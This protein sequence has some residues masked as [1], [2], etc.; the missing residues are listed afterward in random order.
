M[1]NNENI[2]VDFDYQNIIVVD[3]NKVV[4]ENGNVKERYIKQENLVMYANLECT[5]PPRTKL[6]VGNSAQDAVQTLSIASINF[7][8]PQ[9]GDKLTNAYTDEITGKGSLER[10]ENGNFLGIN[11]NV[12]TSIRRADKPN[13]FYNLKQQSTE[14]ALG[15]VDTG[16]LGMTSI[17]I[18]YN[19]DFL[20]VINVTLEDVKGRALFESGNNSPYRAFF[21]YP[22]P[23]F[24]L[25]LK[26][27]YGKA[28]KYPLM[29]QDFKAKVDSESGNFTIDLKFFTYRYSMLS[30]ISMQSMQTVPHMYRTTI[31]VDTNKNP[32]IKT[33]EVTKVELTKGYQKVLEVY[34]DYKSKGLI[35]ENFPPLTIVQLQRKLDNFIQ[36][37]LNNFP[38]Q[39]LTAYTSAQT[40]RDLLNS[41][42]KEITETTNPDSWFVKYIDQKNYFILNN[43]LK[44]YELLG[45]NIISGGVTPRNI[46]ETIVNSELESICVKYSKS[47]GKENMNN[48]PDFGAN[49]KDDKYR[50]SEFKLKLSDFQI[51][52]SEGDLDYEK[53]YIQQTG[54]QPIDSGGTETSGF[55]FYKAQTQLYFQQVSNNQ[56]YNI[57]ENQFT[58]APKILYYFDGKIGI[59]KKS[60]IRKVE[61]QSKELELQFEKYKADQLIKL[62]ETSD[63]GIGFAP[64]LRNVLAV[65]Y[66][67]GE[68]Y[69]RLIDDVHRNSWDQRSNP[70]RFNA[71]NSAI[72]GGDQ[73]LDSTT[74]E[75]KFVYPWPEICVLTTDEKESR[76]DVR[77]P[78][79]KDLAEQFQAYDFSVWPE[80]EFVE[81]YISGTVLRNS[82]PSTPSIFENNLTQSQYTS[83][84]ALE[85]PIDN[86][87]Y[88]NKEQ[89][90][91]LYEIWER[92]YVI[93]NY[94]N[95]NRGGSNFKQVYDTIATIESNNILKSLGDTNPFLIKALKEYGLNSRNF[96][97]V[98]R[99]I[100]NEGQGE[101]WQTHIRGYYNTPYI[102]NI[103]TN[104]F[105]LKPFNSGDTNRI[106]TDFPN[107]E[108]FSGYVVDSSTNILTD[109]DIYP[110]T[111]KNWCKMNLANGKFINDVNT[112]NSTSKV[113]QVNQSSK[114]ICNFLNDDSEFQ[115]RPISNFNYKTVNQPLLSLITPY[116][117]ENIKNLYNIR[118]TSFSQ[119]HPTEGNLRY[120][121]YTGPTTATQTTSILNT[122]YFIN[123]IQDGLV[124][125]RNSEAYPYVSGAYLFLNSLPL[126]TLRERYKSLEVAQDGTSNPTDLDYI[127]A[128]LKKFNAVHKIPYA[129]I[130]RYGSIWHRYKEYIKNG[131]D[132]LSPIWTN[133]DRNFNYDP[134]NSSPQKLY[135]LTINGIQKKIRLQADTIVGNQTLTDINV[136]F[137]PKLIN[138][139]SSFFKGTPLFDDYSDATIQSKIDNEFFITDGFPNANLT[140][141]NGVDENNPNRSI[142]ISSWSSFLKVNSTLGFVLPSVGLNSNQF[143][144]ENFSYTDP[145]QPRMVNEVNN[146]STLYDGSVRLAWASPNYGYFDNSKLLIPPPTKY[147]KKIFT[148]FSAKQENFSISGDDDYSDISELFSVFNKDILDSF[149]RE[150]LNF[151]K[152]IFDTNI[153]SLVEDTAT[154]VDQAVFSNFQYLIRNILKVTPTNGINTPTELS[155]LGNNVLNNMYQVIGKFLSYDYYLKFGNPNNFNQRIFKSF[156][157]LGSNLTDPF[158]YN[159]YTTNSPNALPSFNNQFPIQQ[160]QTTYPTAWEALQEYVGFSEFTGLKYASSGSAIFDFFIDNN[161][162]FGEDTIKNLYPLIKI[163]A[164]Q[165]LKD[166]SYNA[167]KF[168]GTL[169][170]II[171][172]NSDFQDKI[173]NSLMQKLTKELPNVNETP[174]RNIPSE[175]KGDV[176][177]IALWQ[178]FKGLN[179]RWIAGT[180]VSYKTLFED[181]LFLDRAGRDIGSEIYIDVFSLNQRIRDLD[182]KVSLL[183]FSNEL[184]KT[185]NFVVF[186]YPSY[187]NFYGVQS[188]IKNST[189][190][191]DSSYDFANNLFGTHMNVDLVESS[192][193]MVCLYGGKPST[194]LDGGDIVSN[195]KND[196]FNL[197]RVNQNPCIQDLTNKTD[198]DKSNRLVG[199]TVDFG[200]INQG[201]FTKISVGQDN[202]KP[203]KETLDA[204][205]RLAS[206]GEGRGGSSQYLS[207]YDI[208]SSRSYKCDITMMG[209]VLIQPTMYFNL[210]HIPLFNGPYMITSVN[211]SINP[212]SFTTKFDGIRQSVYSYPKV[213]DPLETIRKSFIDYFK[214]SFKQQSTQE[215]QS[216]DNNATEA[217]ASKV[218]NTVSKSENAKSPTCSASTAFSDFSL[219]SSPQKTKVTAS[220]V[221][222]F[223]KTKYGTS[224]NLIYVIMTI[225][226][227]ETAV[228]PE[229]TYFESYENNYAGLKLNLKDSAGNDVTF[230][231]K[232]SLKQNYICMTTATT[233]PEQYPLATFF[234]FE[235]CVDFI[236]TRMS[237]RLIKLQ[238]L[239]NI[240]STDNTNLNDNSEKLSKFVYDFWPVIN[241]GSYEKSTNKNVYKELTKKMI[242]LVNSNI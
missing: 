26:G 185:N 101:S 89:V 222:N 132:I 190:K 119:Q 155:D 124:K 118:S 83:V 136:G 52:V 104:T 166:S 122:P 22:Y 29:L 197:K 200:T 109:Y 213:T 202:G 23:I 49:S 6:S 67:N 93:S 123:S 218:N 137:Y 98:L 168:T 28:V 134:I 163:Y 221:I 108:S 131:S 78:G 167:S 20:P 147:M 17:N 214:T 99:H 239:N 90:K 195:F 170:D 48:V 211:H 241:E 217:D 233:P 76:Y 57:R 82:V 173:F 86:Q 65:F 135:T 75:E 50:T 64:T 96:E 126:A 94:T 201:V 54:L 186:T 171:N 38:K 187:I 12:E 39:D 60:F 149:E 224:N 138:D 129:W 207:M 128:T 225:M 41:I 61:E 178:T 231:N 242:E 15:S 106:L 8:K 227:Q 84:N 133:F 58:P 220:E 27:Y 144:I 192:P 55:T 154:T 85:F 175:L 179:D 100:S 117:S 188:P 158:V 172:N 219:I 120:K 182:P 130:L 164:T 95:L 216:V 36:N 234:N 174:T 205:S 10:D 68:A 69:L 53:T 162:E 19:L 107:I 102:R 5:V 43:G 236:A 30:E 34:N 139:F 204:L 112:I 121:N 229:Y 7:L 150:F 42:I 151:S 32:I 127:Y 74:G 193:K 88:F 56:I 110:F 4:D 24:Y 16:L 142:Y 145:I 59:L 198:W 113:I 180:N 71:I 114:I 1:V 72:Q 177:K 51:E 33:N 21:S 111:D 165:K 181:I 14:G 161:V 156:A 196:A 184:I 210:E 194:H 191:I 157:G 228:S 3:P 230:A 2:F 223:I 153:T 25:T 232:S 176:T 115:K 105:T 80:V 37:V 46:N 116:T 208:Y 206:L 169:T 103:T 79:D 18:Q 70:I 226:G 240:T 66:A 77:Y 141:Q 159:P 87:V 209:N 143:L 152:S 97:A 212:G 160:I 62:L 215:N 203:T 9:K 199:F 183:A 81:E 31:N 73:T 125:F 238:S 44:V 11:Q 148:D 35:P 91:Y 235:D 45:K 140:A 47:T 63:R 13:E 92:L 40:Y 189:P 146:N 237:D